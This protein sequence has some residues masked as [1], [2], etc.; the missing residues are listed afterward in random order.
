VS[1]P[2]FLNRFFVNR[3][4]VVSNHVFDP[5]TRTVVRVDPVVRTGVGKVRPA[6]MLRTEGG[7]TFTTLT[8]MRTVAKVSGLN[9][10]RGGSS[11]T[12]TRATAGFKTDEARRSA[13]SIY[14]RSVADGRY[15]RMHERSAYRG[16][17]RRSAVSGRPYGP[18]ASRRSNG[19]F[20]P[21]NGQGRPGRSYN[22]N[23]AARGNE[24][25]YA[26][27]GQ[28]VGQYSPPMRGGYQTTRPMSG[29]GWQ[30]RG[31]YGHSYAFPRRQGG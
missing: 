10:V 2:F 1:N 6:T 18:P 8:E 19:S 30:G 24:R 21:Y 20:K 23:G 9:T 5:V 17:E 16:G 25:R 3:T 11:M 13:E 26:A 15:G 31:S 4:V 29:T 27:P 28:S 7:R 14:S 22:Y 12:S